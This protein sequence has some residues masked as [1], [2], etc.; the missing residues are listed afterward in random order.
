[1]ERESEI[2]RRTETLLSNF[3]KFSSMSG[4]LATEPE[5]LSPKDPGTHYGGR[6]EETPQ[7]S[8]LTSTN[9]HTNT[10]AHINNNNLNS[11]ASPA[12]R[13]S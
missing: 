7:S 12:L 10:H 2:K 1:M 8:P 13:R 4:M 11:R 6:R 9:I 3:Y 5:D